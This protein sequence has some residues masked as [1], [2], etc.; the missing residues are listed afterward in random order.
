MCYIL[1]TYSSFAHLV[2]ILY[3]NICVCVVINMCL[4]VILTSHAKTMPGWMADGLET[5]RVAAPHLCPI[6]LETRMCNIT[7]VCSEYLYH[8]WCDTD[9]CEV[10]DEWFWV[11][12]LFLLIILLYLASTRRMGCRRTVYIKLHLGR[13]NILKWMRCT[14]IIKETSHTKNSIYIIVCVNFIYKNTH[15]H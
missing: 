14:Y 4:A 8:M 5:H 11:F 10:H 15:I 9:R 7:H 6:F 12:F 13:G 1:L 3:I 2:N